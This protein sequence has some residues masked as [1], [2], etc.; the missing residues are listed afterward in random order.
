MSDKRIESI[1]L[2]IDASIARAAGG[3]ES[4]DPLGSVCREVLIRVRGICHRMAYGERMKEEW[5]RHMSRFA[6]AWLVSMVSMNKLVLVDD[7]PESAHLDTIRAH[8][9]DPGLVEVMEKDAHLLAAATRT[10]SRILSLDDKIR[11]HFAGKLRTHAEVLALVWVNPS[12]PEEDA[13]EWLNQDAPMEA[14]R[15]LGRLPSIS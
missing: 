8:A 4:K 13:I 15:T 5:H 11:H 3:F 12:D 1:C 2:V 10:A 14:S 9:A 6:T 7:S